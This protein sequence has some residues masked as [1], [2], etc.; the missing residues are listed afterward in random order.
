MYGLRA[1]R[2]HHVYTVC[3]SS[4]MYLLK[5]TPNIN[6]TALT[7]TTTQLT[8]LSIHR[9]VNNSRLRIGNVPY[10]NILYTKLH[11]VT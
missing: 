7:T 9:I 4:H 8:W 5:R 11:E 2:S 3:L 6:G 1:L 10:V